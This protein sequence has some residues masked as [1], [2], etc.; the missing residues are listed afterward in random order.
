[1]EGLLQKALMITAF[2]ILIRVIASSVF[3]K[4]LGWRDSFLF[5]ISH[6]MPLTLLVAIAT[7]AYHAKSIDNFHYL[8]FIL[9]SL[10][11]VIIVMTIIKVIQKMGLQIKKTI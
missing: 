5:G 2:M 11:E 10:F 3:I 8:A 7:L 9:A 1:M 6:A 4:V